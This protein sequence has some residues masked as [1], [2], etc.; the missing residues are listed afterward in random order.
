[1]K[2][3][4]LTVGWNSNLKEID[5]MNQEKIM[6]K[7]PTLEKLSSVHTEKLALLNFLDFLGN[8]GL[9]LGFW[10]DTRFVPSNTKSESLIHEY[11]EIDDNILEKERQQLLADFKELSSK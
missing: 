2:D 10:D 8:K 7:Y 5:N 9:M 6:E 4:K 11:L 3:K 1:M